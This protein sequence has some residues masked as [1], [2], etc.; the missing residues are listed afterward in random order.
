VLFEDT[1]AL[2]KNR[3]LIDPCIHLPDGHSKFVLGHRDG[4]HNRQRGAEQENSSNEFRES[5]IHMRD[6]L[7]QSKDHSRCCTHQ[8]TRPGRAKAAQQ[9]RFDADIFCQ[10]RSTDRLGRRRQGTWLGSDGLW[11]S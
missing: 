3:R 7:I 4:R 9:S 6:I 10:R 8:D 5:S 1:D 2:A 11:T